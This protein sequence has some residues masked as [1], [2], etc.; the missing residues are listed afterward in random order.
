[1][2]VMFKSY[3]LGWLVTQQRLWH[4][5]IRVKKKTEAVVAKSTSIITLLSSLLMKL[6]MQIIFKGMCGAVEF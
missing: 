4:E 6:N 1:M 5:N 3:V 2:V